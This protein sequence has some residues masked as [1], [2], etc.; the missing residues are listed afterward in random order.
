L[1]KDGLLEVRDLRCDALVDPMLF[2]SAEIIVLKILRKA[3]MSGLNELHH[4]YTL[5]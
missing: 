5:T 1:Y 3:L 2:N 4:S